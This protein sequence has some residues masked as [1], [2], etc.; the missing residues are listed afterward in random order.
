M[1]R[2]DGLSCLLTGATFKPDV[3]AVHGVVANL[4]HIIPNSVSDKVSVNFRHG[5]LDLISVISLT[6]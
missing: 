4:A 5:F 6:L 1:F 3:T 2:R